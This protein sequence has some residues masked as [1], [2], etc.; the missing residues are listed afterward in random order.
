MA[1][2]SE[3]TKALVISSSIEYHFDVPAFLYS[4]SRPKFKLCSFS[5]VTAEIATLT[6]EAGLK[7]PVSP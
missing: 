6:V 7:K 5:K 3:I 4:V 1:S 2:L